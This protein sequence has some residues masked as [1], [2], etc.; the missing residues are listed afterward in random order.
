MHKLLEYATV[1]AS[2]IFLLQESISVTFSPVPLIIFLSSDF[3]WLFPSPQGHLRLVSYFR[4]VFLR[5]TLCGTHPL[6][7]LFL[8]CIL[9]LRH[10]CF[11]LS[12]SLSCV[13]IYFFFFVDCIF[14]FITFAVIQRMKPKDSFILHYFSYR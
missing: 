4:G 13:S 11:K 2:L 7:Q 9:L 1:Y 6:L 3:S 12:I 14:F 5:Q 8:G 10:Y